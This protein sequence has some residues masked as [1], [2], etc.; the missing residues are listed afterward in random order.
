MLLVVKVDSLLFVMFKKFFVFNLMKVIWYVIV[1][2]GG[3]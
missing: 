3:G 2:L 1:F